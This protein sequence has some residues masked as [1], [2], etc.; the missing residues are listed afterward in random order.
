LLAGAPEFDVAC[1]G[2]AESV[3]AG[4]ARSLEDRRGWEHIPG[5]IFR[6]G[7]RLAVGSLG[8]RPLAPDFTPANYHPS[9]YPGLLDGGKIL[10]FTLPQSTGLSHAAHYHGDVA[11][12]PVHV[13]D[14]RQLRA[15][16]LLLHEMYGARAFHFTGSRTPRDAVAHLAAECLSLPFDVGYSREAHVCETDSDLAIALTQSGCKSLEFSPLTGSQRLLSDFYGEDWTISLAEAA[17]RACKS[18]Q[19]RLHLAFT[20]PCPA[21]DYHSRAETFRMLR[22]CQPYSADFCLPELHPGSA[23]RQHSADFGFSVADRKL[24]R[25][26]ADPPLAGSLEEEAANLPFAIGHLDHNTTPE[27]VQEAFFELT[28][29]GIGRSPGAMAG[30]MAEI[31]GWQAPYLEILESAVA[32]LDLEHLHGA[33]EQFNA[34]STASINAVDLSSG[35]AIR[36]AVG[37]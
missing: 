14:A 20:F 18:Q 28:E 26:I 1:V 10:L 17:F 31:A 29:L 12:H 21:D 19:L 4:L 9:V 13:R 33:I 16:M 24:A 15:E 30:L 35:A 23:W 37:D 3:L 11:L 8:L 5:L 7:A 36:K 22:R 25:W 27:K 2:P 34:H 6:I 32:T